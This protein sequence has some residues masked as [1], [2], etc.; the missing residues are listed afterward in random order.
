[1]GRHPSRRL[2]AQ[3]LDLELGA[4]TARARCGQCSPPPR[5]TTTA[6]APMSPPESSFGRPFRLSSERAMARDLLAAV[7][8]GPSGC[9]PLNRSA[10]ARGQFMRN[11]LTSPARLF[12]APNS[13]APPPLEPARLWR[14]ERKTWN[15]SDDAV[16]ALGGVASRR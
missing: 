3:A 16:H 4:Q 12:A 6:G 14:N 1:M 11:F 5:F 15:L 7:C 9:P 10:W 13:T 2:R 8:S